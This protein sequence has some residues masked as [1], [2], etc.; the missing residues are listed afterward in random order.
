MSSVKDAAA[1]FLACRRMAVTGVSGAPTGQASN[2]IYTFLRGRG[3]AVFPVNPHAEVVEGDRAWPTVS[4]IPGGV[5]AVIVAT[6]PEHVQATIE[7]AAALGITQVWMHRA[8]GG[9]SVN[10]EAATWGRSHG[11]TVIEGGCPLMFHSDADRGHK[12]MCR[13]LTWTGAVPR[14]VEPV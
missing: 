6:A 11:I 12:L 7:E 1:T 3:Y 8:L 4:S 2:G 5:E 14:T 10:A 9:G 13:V